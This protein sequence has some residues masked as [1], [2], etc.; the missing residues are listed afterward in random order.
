MC[1]IKRAGEGEDY[2]MIQSDGD[3]MKLN[4]TR[5]DADNDRYDEGNYFSDLKE[6]EYYK[7]QFHYG[8]ADNGIL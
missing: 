8:D 1:D 3:I 2:Y 6:A 5:S 4:D 7:E